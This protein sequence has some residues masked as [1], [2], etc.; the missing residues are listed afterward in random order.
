MEYGFYG[1]ECGHIFWRDDAQIIDLFFRSSTLPLILRALL[2]R[3]CSRITHTYSSV[4]TRWRDL[5]QGV[6]QDEGW[7]WEWTSQ[8]LGKW[9]YRF[10][11]FCHGR[12]LPQ[13][14]PECE[15]GILMDQYDGS[16]GEYNVVDWWRLW[17]SGKFHHKVFKKK[18]GCHSWGSSFVGGNCFWKGHSNFVPERRF[19]MWCC[20]L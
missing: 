9:W 1:N 3:K 12:I 16:Q 17:G 14:G 18:S 15:G 10:Y 11:K 13:K 4:M 20:L 8:V 6:Q 2:R 7:H 19:R 5:W